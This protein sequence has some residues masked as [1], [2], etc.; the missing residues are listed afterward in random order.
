MSLVDD[1]A[2]EVARDDAIERIDKFVSCAEEA[3]A[4]LTSCLRVARA[5]AKH[6][7]DGKAM[8]SCPTFGVTDLA[9]AVNRLSLQEG[10]ISDALDRAYGL[11]QGGES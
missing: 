8:A 2:I 5:A 4:R 10:R 9:A 1:R 11:E 6:L 3:E 7:R